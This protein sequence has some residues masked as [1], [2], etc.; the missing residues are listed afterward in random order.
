MARGRNAPHDARVPRSSKQV[1]QGR[2]P[3]E[4]A[5]TA[6]IVRPAAPAGSSRGTAGR[7]W[8]A[9]RWGAIRRGG[10][11]RLRRS[12]GRRAGGAVRRRNGQRFGERFKCR[13]LAVAPA[14]RRGGTAS[15]IVHDG[16]TDL[17]RGRV[18]RGRGGARTI[19][20]GKG[21]GLNSLVSPRVRRG[22][23]V[24]S[25]ARLREPSARVRPARP[26]G[27]GAAC[28]GV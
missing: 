17:P 19:R 7:R 1:S 3:G 4:T 23:G 21:M 20:L 26:G 22:Q 24:G 18:S 25:L 5:L 2:F 6:R 28:E 8:G 11:R 14:M 27:P 9:R 12:G 15:D 10:S 13:G 16:A